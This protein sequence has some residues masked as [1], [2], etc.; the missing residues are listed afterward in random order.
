LPSPLGDAYLIVNAPTET[1]SRGPREPRELLWKGLEITTGA[2]R[3]HRHDVLLAQAAEKGLS[4]EPMRW[5][6]DCFRY[7]CP[8]HGGFGL[9]LGRLLMVLLGLDSI[10]D[11][12]FLF[13]GPSRLIP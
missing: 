2:Q 9:G 11:A 6:L 13:R 8:P 12:T 4:P 1:S 10:R 5:Y 3:E 7:G